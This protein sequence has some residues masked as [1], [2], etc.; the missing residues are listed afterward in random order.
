MSVSAH[1]LLGDA[2]SPVGFGSFSELSVQLKSGG[3]L[4]SCAAHELRSPQRSGM[5][6][7]FQ[8]PR[9]VTAGK[10]RWGQCVL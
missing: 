2:P 5:S 8:R 10:S 1:A 6:A 7:L 3:A 9:S 4:Y